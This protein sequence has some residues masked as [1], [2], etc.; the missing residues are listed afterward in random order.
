MYA[1]FEYSR[2]DVAAMQFLPADR[3]LWGSDYPHIEGTFPSSE[4]IV[5]ESFA[6]VSEEVVRKVTEENA[7]KLYGI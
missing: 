7:A 5:A 2:Q 3:F 4:K 1:T 6:D